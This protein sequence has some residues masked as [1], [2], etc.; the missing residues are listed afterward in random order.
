[1]ATL[2]ELQSKD[3]KELN[4]LLK[5][6]DKSKRGKKKKEQQGGDA[7][8]MPWQNYNT[9]LSLNTQALNANHYGHLSAQQVGSPTAGYGWSQKGGGTD[10]L[11]DLLSFDEIV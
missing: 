6:K 1:M 4:A 10:D 8:P 7:T 3:L 9:N 2:K 5:N 11:S